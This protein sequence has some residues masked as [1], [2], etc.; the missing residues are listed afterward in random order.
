MRRRIIIQVESQSVSECRFGSLDRAQL[1][2]LTEAFRHWRETAP[3]P[4]IRRV[5][6]RYWLAFLFLRHTGARIGEIL[7]I[8]D[9]VD[10][11]FSEAHVHI[12][13]LDEETDRLVLRSI[14]VP[15]ELV[16]EL[17]RYLDEFPVMRGKVFSLDQGNFRR[18]FYRRAE[19]A[20]IPRELSHPHILRHTRAIELI[21][22]GVPLS[23]VRDLLGH[24]LSSTTALYMRRT[25]VTSTHFLK[26]RGV[27]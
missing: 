13:I 7:N 25:E 23:M 27:L 8:N 24:A 26:D 16:R 4:Y 12:T 3:T 10:I 21:E 1:E 9:L 22:A 11:D 5:R 15:A 20:L 2:R 17:L 14:P 19:E 6:G 18:E